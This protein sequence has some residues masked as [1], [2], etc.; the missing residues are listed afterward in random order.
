M[1]LI[2]REQDQVI[3]L[4]KEVTKGT[5][6]GV[7][8]ADALLV[9]DIEVNTLEGEVTDRKNFVGFMGSQGAIRL[10][11]YCTVKFAV[12]LGG[13]G[14]KDTPVPYNAVYM[15]AAHAEAITATTKVDYTPV[16]ETLDSASLAYFVGPIKHLVTAL[17]GSLDWEL[18]TKGLPRLVFNGVGL[19][20]APSNAGA[21]TGINL[22]AFKV[23]TPIN[24]DT[25][26]LC[27]L[28]SVAVGMTDLKLTGGAK[29]EYFNEVNTETVDIVSRESKLSITFRE[30]DPATKNWWT[31]AQSNAY[32]PLAF[33]R[34]TDVTDD[35][36]IFEL[37]IAQLQLRNCK[38]SFDKGISYLALE[39]DV[40]P[41]TKNSDYV[42]THR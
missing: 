34:G 6:P 5:D 14:V 2:L 39:A 9:H 32:V 31:L 8:A 18:G 17:M 26:S 12:E 19:Y 16:S 4:R 37:S 10:N 1:T 3:L 24:A 20:N 21:P 22:S 42:I 27:T 30:D 38:R 13:S 7:A 23:P 15:I 35:G 11:Q 36:D 40:V 28:D 41:V 29:A 33:Q 25:V